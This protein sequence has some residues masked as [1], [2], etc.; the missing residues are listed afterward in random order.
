MPPLIQVDAF[1]PE[2][3]AGNPA[4]ICLL[5]GPADEAWMQAL[6]QEMNLSETAYVYPLQ[7][8]GPEKGALSPVEE[9]FSLRWFT[10]A[11]EVD[12]CG[13]AT[14]AAAHVLWE[15]DRLP[16]TSPAR[17]HTKSGLLT[18]TKS[19]GWIE[20]DFPAS[21]VTGAAPPDE[22]IDAIG[23][24]PRFAGRTPFDWF[25]EADSEAAL[26]ALAPDFPLLATVET[27]GVIVTARA[28]DPALDFVSRFLAPILGVD[29]DP[30]TGSAHCALAP[31]WAKRLHKNELTARQ[32]SARGGEVRC[33]VEGDRVVLAGQAV[34]VMR[35]EVV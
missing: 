21:P 3:F 27:R 1:T 28:A 7:E 18:C 33:R 12:L 11:A 35:S 20:M 9:A 34:T 32:I 26:S 31:F 19:G 29:E 24:S 30:V 13:H 23:L 2:P 4:A 10:P 16:E 15:E 22:L 5:G 6:A 14:L 8:E 17:F 25:I